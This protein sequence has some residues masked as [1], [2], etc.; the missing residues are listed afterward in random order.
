MRKTKIIPSNFWLITMLDSKSAILPIQTKTTKR[1]R[2]TDNGGKNIPGKA[3]TY[4]SR[5]GIELG[6]R[7]LRRWNIQQLKH[8][9]RL[10]L[11]RQW[12]P[13]AAESFSAAGLRMWGKFELPGHVFHIIQVGKMGKIGRKVGKIREFIRHQCARLVGWI[14]WCSYVWLY[15]DGFGDV[16]R[17][18][19][20]RMWSV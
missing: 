20:L 12:R 6:G 5:H 15:V 19:L 17:N 1:H 14:S 4:W 3:S 18:W 11:C 8:W 7:Y 13:F 2:I 10:V 9:W 16:K